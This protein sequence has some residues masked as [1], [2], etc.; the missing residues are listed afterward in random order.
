M[1][2]FSVFSDNVTCRFEIRK[3]DIAFQSV[4][5]SIRMADTP[6]ALERM[7][8]GELLWHGVLWCGQSCCYSCRAMYQFIKNKRIKSTY[9]EKRIGNNL[10]GNFIRSYK[11]WLQKSSIKTTLF[12]PY[13]FTLSSFGIRNIVILYELKT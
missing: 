5:K 7:S 1:N 12:L 13:C 9:N 3:I 6:Y 10:T 11:I 4:L 8:T 2:N